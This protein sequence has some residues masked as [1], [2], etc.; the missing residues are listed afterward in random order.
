M[1]PSHLLDFKNVFL[2]GSNDWQVH[3]DILETSEPG[4]YDPS[5]EP[6]GHQ[7]SMQPLPFAPGEKGLPIPGGGLPVSCSSQLRE[8]GQ[9]WAGVEGSCL[10]RSKPVSL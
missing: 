8:S 10:P 1:G 6:G 7:G 2:I 3:Q 9:G 4:A 5:S